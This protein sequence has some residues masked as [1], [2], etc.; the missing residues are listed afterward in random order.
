M[1]TTATIED[2]LQAV[3]SD[4]GVEG[5]LHAVDLNSGREVRYR[6]DQLNHLASVGKIP[7]LV[8]LMQSVAAGEHRLDERV[9]IPA[10]GR[11]DGPTGLSTM[12]HE[13]DLSLRD[14]A[15]LMIVV[16]DNHATDV[17]LGMVPPARVTATMRRLGLE[18]TTFET[19]I[20]EMFALFRQ[21]YDG[22]EDEA[23]LRRLRQSDPLLQ[24]ET[25]SWRTTPEEI[26]RLLMLIWKDRAAPA[27][28]C[29]EMRDILY[30]QVWSHR[31]SSGFPDEVKIGAK[32]GTLAGIR[33]ECGV[34]EYPDGGQ[35]AVAVF[36][37][38]NN[39][40]Y[41]NPAADRVIGTAGRLAVDYLRP[42][43]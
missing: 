18:Q 27:E 33:N 11:T 15:Q 25:A 8:T 28:L 35:Y 24:G 34:V 43:S 2:Q 17:I 42:S 37:R 22:I 9:R 39:Y 23:E 26:T 7:I 36:T 32:T 6:S 1:T 12:R 40:A 29:A 10:E 3:F 5:Y 38:T 20:A 41:R 21:R 16:S 4:A 19:T 14:V 31:L 13:A 30:D